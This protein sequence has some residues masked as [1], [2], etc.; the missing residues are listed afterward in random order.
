MGRLLK[1]GV[2]LLITAVFSTINFL[3]CAAGQEICSDGERYSP[4]PE[5]KF[6]WDCNSVGDPILRECPA[7]L[8]WD[9]AITACNL[10]ENVPDC[11]G[12]TRP[13]ITTTTTPTTTTPTTTTRPTT[14]RPTTTTTR[15]PTAAPCGSQCCVNDVYDGLSGHLNATFSPII[16]VFQGSTFSNL[17][18][19]GVSTLDLDCIFNVSSWTGDIIRRA[20][21][22]YFQGDYDIWGYLDLFPFSSLCL[23]SG[24]FSGAGVATFEVQNLDW[25]VGISFSLDQVPDRLTIQILTI[26]EIS[27][28]RIYLN[29]GPNFRINGSP[30]DWE[31]FNANLHSCFHTQLKQYRRE[32]ET[33][34]KF[35]L[36]ERYSQFDHVEISKFLFAGACPPCVTVCPQC[37]N[38]RTAALQ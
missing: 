3:G 30:V 16:E 37:L 10:P 33:K 28:D 4:H 18:T 25:I 15:R 29:L 1:H 38:L 12:G 35:A 23:P 21:N 5:C 19:H 22:F 27:F 13:P 14:T 6:Y 7:D 36:N 17:Y 9:V 34:L 11:V 20:G 2:I 26:H 24:S 32:I 31:A 8:F